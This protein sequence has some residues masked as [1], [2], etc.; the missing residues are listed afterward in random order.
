MTAVSPQLFRKLQARHVR[1]V[2][3]QDQAPEVVGLRGEELGSRG[4]HFDRVAGNFEQEPE[5]VS[6][7][8][9]VINDGYLAR[10]RINHV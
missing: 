2:M 8:I 5:R 10:C 1:H 6:H 3:V 9:V 7:S 4:E